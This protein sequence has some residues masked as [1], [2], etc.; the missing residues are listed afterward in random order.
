[1]NYFYDR[2]LRQFVDASGS[3][4]PLRSLRFMRDEDR[5]M[6]ISIQDNGTAWTATGTAS[7]TF[8]IKAT[9]GELTDTLAIIEPG[10]F[11]E[12]SDIYTGTLELAGEDLSDLLG[13]DF[14]LKLYAQLVITD[15][16]GTHKSDVIPVIMGNDIIRGNEGTPSAMPDPDAYVR[17]RAVVYDAAQ[18]LTSPQ[19][20]QARDNLGLGTAATSNTG[21]FATASH[22]HVSADITD[23]TTSATANTVAKRGAGGQVAFANTTGGATSPAVDATSLDSDAIEGS[24]TNGSGGHFTST[25]GTYHAEFGDTGD[26]RSFVA[27]VS[28]LFGWLRGAYSQTIGAAATLTANRAVL[29]PDASGTVALT[30]TSVQTS[31]LSTEGGASKVF[32]AD[33]SGDF[34]TGPYDNRE[35]GNYLSSSFEDI[36]NIYIPDQ[37][38]LVWRDPA[39]GTA[40][41]AIRHWRGHDL[42]GGEAIFDSVWRMAFITVGPVQFGNNASARDAQ[43]LHIVSGSSSAADTIKPSKAITFQTKRYNGGSETTGYAIMQA[44]S[45]SSS[46]NETILRI[47][48]AENPASGPVDGFSGGGGTYTK[49]NPE[50]TTHF[51]LSA[52]GLWETGKA[53]A[54]VTLTD[55]ATIT[56]TCSKYKTIQVAK[57]RITQ[58]CNLVIS[59]A[60]AGMRGRIFVKQDPTGSRTLTLPSNSIKDP[61]FALSTTAAMTDRLDW[62]YDGTYFYWDIFKGKTTPT[63]SDVSAFIDAGRANISDPGIIDALNDLAISL[64]ASNVDGTGTLWSKAYFILPVAGG[65]ATA[66]SKDLKNAFDVT[67]SGA[68]TTGVTHDANG[69][70]GDGSTGFGISAFD[71]ADAAQNSFSLY[72][73][74]ST[75]SPTT[76]RY[77]MGATNGTTSRALLGFS[78]GG[79]AIAAN[80]TSDGNGGGYGGDARKHFFVTRTGSADY[81]GSVNATDATNTAASVAPWTSPMYVL[82]RNASGSASGFTNANLR[83]VAAFTGLSAAERTAWRAIV[84]TFQTS[85]GRANP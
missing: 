2:T 65:T 62:E 20:T 9:P 17:A 13:T 1:M 25:A 58:N 48:L 61:A 8:G 52:S 80:T 66:H 3:L 15:D 51:E 21:D 78:G 60:E 72:A 41:F 44:T 32:Q 27:R 73:Y 75:T 5:E 74:C 71:M 38:G 49:G 11:S 12:A 76:S 40:T 34:I 24:S 39:T 22:T 16:G 37:Q 83:M 55:G 6:A 35:S 29:L 46:T 31:Q 64:K 56:Q 42:N 85:L 79:L 18:T 47:N 23:A 69:I 50:G 54:F 19:K 57:V 63:D 70:T 67:N 43:C 36:G 45:L 53:P 26:N 28:G 30:E 10:D 7:V 77:M 4:R 59:G 68:W 81:V 14:S 82:A 33:A 84:D